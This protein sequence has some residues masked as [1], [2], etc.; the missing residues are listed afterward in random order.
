M[1]NPV[2]FYVPNLIGYARI[3]SCTVAMVYA[4]HDPILA[5][6]AYIVGQ[7][8]DAFDGMAARALKQTSR[9]GVVL[10]MLTDRMGTCGLMV[11][12]SHLYPTWWGFWTFLLV[13][14]IVS[15]WC[16]MYSKLSL[17][18][19]THKGSN[20]PLL[21]FYY[22]FPYALFVFCAGNEFFFVSMYLLTFFEGPAITLFG[23]TRGL[24]DVVSLALAPLALFKNLMNVVQLFDAVGEIAALPEPTDSSATRKSVKKRA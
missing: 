21:N 17:G 4:F 13:L 23:V 10:D 2:F 5:A 6:I 12:L 15:H 9:F 11:V 19:K 16:Q 18:L 14:D 22:T 20:N 8:L 1:V 24:W 3:V 7:G